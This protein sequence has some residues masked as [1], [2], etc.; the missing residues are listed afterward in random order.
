MSGVRE[1]PLHVN[2]GHDF[3][4]DSPYMFIFFE[5][6]PGK[7]VSNTRTSDHTT[8]TPRTVLTISSGSKSTDAK[9]PE[10]VEKAPSGSTQ[11]KCTNCFLVPLPITQPNHVLASK[12]KDISKTSASQAMGSDDGT[13]SKSTEGDKTVTE[14]P[15]NDEEGAS[16][17]ANYAIP[18]TL[19]VRS[20]VHKLPPSG[21]GKN[22]H[23]DDDG[24]LLLTLLLTNRNQNYAAVHPNTLPPDHPMYRP[25]C[26]PKN[27]QYDP[28][29]DPDNPMFK[30]EHDPI[31]DFLDSRFAVMEVTRT[32]QDG[33]PPVLKMRGA[34][35]AIV[36][37]DRQVQFFKDNGYLVV[38]D[39]LSSD[40]IAELLQCVQEIA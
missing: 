6:H 27:P 22:D 34:A 23:V 2:A 14:E 30:P 35:P 12:A 33:G 39:V 21:S 9:K 36:L 16:F 1:S 32:R 25:E 29:R 15:A 8:D 20:A 18:D 11:G 7:Q 28:Q 31:A 38:P 5:Y 19:D 10:V 4:L 3:R 26:D 40:M 24:P 37:E 17:S 13:A